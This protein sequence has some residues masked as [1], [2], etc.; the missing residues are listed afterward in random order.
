LDGEH[1]EYVRRRRGTTEA[2]TREFLSAVA[3]F[4]SLNDKNIP[5]ME[6]LG[7]DFIGKLDTSEIH[8]MGHSFGGATAFH[9]ARQKRP[10]SIIAHD[11]ATDWMP[12]DT[13]RSLFDETRL[14]GSRLN[15]TG[16][17]GGLPISTSDVRENSVHDIEM[18]VLFSH[19]WHSKK[20]SGAHI[21][22]DMHKRNQV[23]PKGGISRV[24]VID[25]AH[26]NEFSDSSMMTPCWLAR[27]VSIS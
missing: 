8:Y 14:Q 12:D 6:M 27:L 5:E 25:A 1:E 13:R 7:L 22:D 24:G 10:T 15:Y 4:V 9:A 3:T 17:T 16:G 26:H 21:L 18:L 11:P 23:G 20:W 2:R 19:Q